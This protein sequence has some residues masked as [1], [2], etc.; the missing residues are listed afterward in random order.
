[1]PHPPLYSLITVVSCVVIFVRLATYRRRNSRHR[2]AYAWIA[3]CMC[4][5]SAVVGIKVA[6]GLRPPVGPV[7]ALCTLALAVAILHV[8]GDVAHLLQGRL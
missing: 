1:M 6:L 4:T 7:E 8:R 3:W 2:P 5:C